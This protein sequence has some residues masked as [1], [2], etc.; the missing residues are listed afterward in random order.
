MAKETDMI[1]AC[2]QCGENREH[3]ERFIGR[4]DTLEEH[5]ELVCTQCGTVSSTEQTLAPVVRM[6]F[7][8]PAPA[9]PS[10]LDKGS[11]LEPFLPCHC[12]QRTHNHHVRGKVL[13]G[14]FGTVPETE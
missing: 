13:R 5:R 2:W 14:T 10:A 12:G 1:R 4:I 6:R 7:Y 8:P 3:D 9:E 11:A